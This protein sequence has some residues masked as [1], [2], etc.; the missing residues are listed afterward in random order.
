MLVSGVLAAEPTR[1]I[2]KKGDRTVVVVADE[3]GWITREHYND[4]MCL[5]IWESPEGRRVLFTYDHQ[6]RLIQVDYPHGALVKLAWPEQGP[7]H[8]LCYDADNE[9]FAVLKLD[10]AGTTCTWL[11]ADG[12]EQI[13]EPKFV[14]D[15]PSLD[16]FL[17]K[18]AE[19]VRR[20]AKKDEDE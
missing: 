6:L 11:S 8:G 20:A 7:A 3:D 9:K 12:K 19:N 17:K 18:A 13:D 5:L 10:K 2:P 15:I 1:K 14:R 16:Y 4:L